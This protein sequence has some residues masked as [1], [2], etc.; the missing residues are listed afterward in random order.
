VTPGLGAGQ[1]GSILRSLA[2]V[3][4]GAASNLD[5]APWAGHGATLV[6]VTPAAGAPRIEVRDSP[7]AGSTSNQRSA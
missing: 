4:A 2:L 5:T 7:A 6:L 3:E 1:A